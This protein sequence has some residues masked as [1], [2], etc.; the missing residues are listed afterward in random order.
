VEMQRAKKTGETIRAAQEEGLQT[1]FKTAQDF[2]KGDFHA[3]K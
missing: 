1:D 3:K 2:I